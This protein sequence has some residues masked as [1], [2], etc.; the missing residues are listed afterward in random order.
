M[1]WKEFNITAERDSP[2]IHPRCVSKPR[3]VTIIVSGLQKIMLPRLQDDHE[4][5]LI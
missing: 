5:G 3:R 2:R 1:L 4:S